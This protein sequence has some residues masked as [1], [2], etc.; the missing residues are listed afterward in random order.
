MTALQRDLNLLVIE[1]NPGDFVLIEEYLAEMVNAVGIHHAKTF[2]EVKKTLQDNSSFDVILLDLTLPDLS[3]E[4]LVEQVVALS[5]QIPVVVLTGYENQEF[6]LK[7]LSLGV[8]DYVLKDEMTPFMLGKVI[9]YSIERNRVRQSLQKSEKKY[10]DI[11]DL[12]PQPMFLIDVRLR[13][14]RDINEAAVQQYGYSKEEFIGL[15]LKDIRPNKEIEYFES[16][17]NKIDNNDSQFYNTS[18]KHQRKN[19]EVFDVE[20]STSE[21]TLDGKPMRMALAEDVTEKIK[22]EREVKQKSELLA[23]NAKVTGVLIRNENWLEALDQT[24]GVIGEAVDVDRVYYFENHTDPETSKL[25]TSQ[26]IEWTAD[27]IESELHNPKLQNLDTNEFPEI[28]SVLSN[29]EVFQ[30]LVKDLPE[31][32]FRDILES[33]NITSLLHFPIF[34]DETFYGYVGFDDC[35]NARLWSEEEVQYLQTLG[36]NIANAIKLRN[37]TSELK[38]NEY[39]FKSMVEQG[40]DLIEILD[41]DGNF[42]FVSP[43]MEKILGWKYEDILGENAFDY[44]HPDDIK[45]AREDFDKLLQSKHIEARPFRFRNRSD[46]WDWLKCKGTNMQDD[47]I[48]NG[49]LIMASEITEQKY[50]NG[51]QKLERDVLEKNTLRKISIKNIAKEFLLGIEQL[52]AGIKTSVTLIKDDTLFNY[53]SPSLP[54]KFLEQI[55]GIPI[56]ENKG[57]C[58]TAAYINEAVIV[59]DIFKD[60][61]WEN[62]KWMGEKYNFSACWSI[63][64]RDTNGEVFATFAVYYETPS[65]PTFYEQNTVE[66]ATHILR[67]LFDSEEK[68]KAEK[69]VK[70]K[71]KLLAAT[72]KVS[73]ALINTDDLFKVLDESFEVIG[74][75]ADVDRVA[76]FEAQTDPDT[77]KDILFQHLEWSADNIEPQLDN[78]EVKRISFDSFPA[79]MDLLLDNKP[80]KAVISDLPDGDLKHLFTQQDIV[81]ILVL[82]IFV[83]GDFFGCIGFDDCS[84][85][86][87]WDDH[88]IQYLQTIASNI[89]ASIKLQKTRSE[90]E[91]REERFKALVQEGS[92]LI[93]IL[94]ENMCFKYVSP[95]VGDLSQSY[96]GMEAI[97]FVHPKDKERVKRKLSQLPHEKRII[98]QPYRLRDHKGSYYW[99]ETIF[100]NLLD[101]PA[102]EGYIANSR[103]VTQQI[104]REEKLREL[105]LV[106]SKTTDSVV[107]TDYKGYITWVNKAFENLTGY[108]LAEIKGKKPGHFL[109]GK[110]TNPEAVQN[111]SDALNSYESIETTILNYTKSGKPYWLNMSIDPIFDEDENCTHFI[112]IE[113]DVTEKM[114]REKELQKSLERYDIVNKATSDTIWDLDIET[115][116]MIYNSNIYNMFG[117]DKQS[118]KNV[119]TWW[120]D[121]IHP[122]DLETVDNALAEVLKNEDD[123][124]QMEYR[125]QAADGS[126]KYIFDRAFVIKNAQDKPVRMI[127]AM[128]DTT[129][130]REEEERLKLLESVITNTSESVVILNAYPGKYGRE[131][132]FVNKAFTKLSGYSKNDVTG[133]TLHFLNGPDTDEETRAEL[134]TAMENFEPIEVEFINYKKNGD[135]FWI[136]TSM[137]PVENMDGDY[138]HWVAIGRDITDHK[139]SE[140]AIKSS[141]QEKETLLAEIHHR[142]KNNLAVVSGM[143]QLQAFES[144][145]TELQAKLYDSVVR[146]K[147]MATVHEL[148]YQSNSFSQLEF[149]DTLS[150]LAKNISETLQTGSEISLNIQCEPIKL[151]INQAIPAS[152]IVNEVLTNTYKHAFTGTKS[153]HIDF[154]LTETNGLIEI[155]ITDN[156]VGFSNDDI[157]NS[158]SLGMHLINVLTEQLDGE[159]N[160]NSLETGTAFKLSFERRKIDKG[161]GNSTFN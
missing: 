6:G 54:N 43:N 5:G 152:L 134:R 155:K 65:T 139:Q 56:G 98:L 35:T 108:T 101:E 31:S 79:V 74:K 149:S 1:D 17:I 128:Q 136:N 36:S 26:K 158:G 110:D 37:T 112:S 44:I 154:D 120:K 22:A 57:S 4:T 137:V 144:D 68:E 122:D 73:S 132:V 151:N 81:S 160:Y 34:V 83:D 46:K 59:T 93:G 39:K 45:I 114:E 109:Q 76:L 61:I 103:N 111:I 48:I 75:A 30:T 157:M 84:R 104:Q 8:A 24:L 99:V 69:A 88:E 138:T 11:F 72:A 87:K 15:H 129:Q 161:I 159:H 115:G 21:I 121:K 106:A 82:P 92:D 113:R 143:M 49:L 90:L 77:G 89:S 27:G 156:G 145:N 14:I 96:L 28:Y 50:Y 147:T 117:Y 141:L 29:N 32:D 85:K 78:P 23:A 38:V 52:H 62:Y 9:A 105:S 33:Q 153:G 123:R 131:I 2:A 94:D 97:E 86:R 95:S 148:L 20:L 135:K 107:I 51:L 41:K 13:T 142:V 64:I 67:I 119:G 100:T 80:F 42:Q 47:E 55:D 53:C 102:V 127:G 63:P 146:I 40:G 91:Q 58:G 7:T 3:G 126:Y 10:R 125:F 16:E 133:E 116:K 66:R 118:V 130:E 140:E 71:N 70:Q 12:S 124:F 19:G 60:P 18:V 150:K 25:F